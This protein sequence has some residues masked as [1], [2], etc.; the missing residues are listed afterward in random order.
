MLAKLKVEC[1]F[2]FTVKLEGMFHD[3]KSSTDTMQAYHDHLSRTTVHPLLWLFPVNVM[4]DIYVLAHVLFTRTVYLSSAARQASKSFEQFYLSRHSGRKLTWQPSLG[5]A[6]VRV[7]F[8]ARKHDLNISSF[9]LVILLL[10]ENL[11][12]GGYLTKSKCSGS[13]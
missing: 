9:A 12:E 4:H 2:Q 10:F 13:I 5:N 7:T 1:G 6:D 11:E 8:K 3:M